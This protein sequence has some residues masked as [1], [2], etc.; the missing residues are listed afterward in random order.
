MDEEENVAILRF[1]GFLD[2]VD[3]YLSALVKTIQ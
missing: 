1:M 3:A 2:V